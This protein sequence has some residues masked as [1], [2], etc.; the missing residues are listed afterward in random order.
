MPG[1]RLFARGC[2]SDA[3]CPCRDSCRALTN[4]GLRHCKST[5]CEHMPE[6][7][8][9]GVD[10]DIAAVP[11]IVAGRSHA[12]LRSHPWPH[13]RPRP[14]VGMPMPHRRGG[15]RNRRNAGQ[16]LHSEVRIRGLRSK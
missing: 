14:P 8:G 12:Q 10:K 9:R 13:R 15:V 16:D 2:D 7:L 6:A 1:S 11:Q 4:V 3:G 5:V